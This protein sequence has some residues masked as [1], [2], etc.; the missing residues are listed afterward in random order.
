MATLT[1]TSKASLLRF[2]SFS[3]SAAASSILSP[4]S[5]S[6]DVLTAL[7]EMGLVTVFLDFI[8]T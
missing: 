2:E 7:R 8:Q 4:I 5:S 3:Q 6:E 1:F